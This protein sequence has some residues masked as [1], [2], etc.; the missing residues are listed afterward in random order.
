MESGEMEG[1][2]ETLVDC[3]EESEVATI[4]AWVEL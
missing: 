3:R 2:E 1:V 4:V